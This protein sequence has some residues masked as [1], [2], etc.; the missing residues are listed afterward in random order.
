[1]ATENNDTVQPPFD[2]APHVVHPTG[3]IMIWFTEPAGV[4]IQVAQ[5][6]HVNA[7]LARYAC[8]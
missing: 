1:M 7:E 4:V 6:T 5:P 3:A 2:S 8:A